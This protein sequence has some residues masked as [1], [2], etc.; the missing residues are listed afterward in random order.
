MLKNLLPYLLLISVSVCGQTKLIVM[1]GFMEDQP[2]ENVLVLSSDN[3]ELGKTNSN[4]V[5]II[6][7]SQE[8]VTLVFDGYKDRKVFAYGKDITV[9]LLP[10]T[11]ELNSAEITNDDS[12]A[13]R[14]IRQVIQDKKKNSIENLKTYEYKSYSKFLVTANKD[15]LPYIMDPRNEEDSSYNDIRKLL[16][17]SHLMLGERAMDHKFSEK[18]GHKNVVKATRISGTKLPMYEFIAMQP[19]SHNF[20][21][22]KIDFFFREF[23]NPI[24]KTGLQEYRYRISEETTLEGRQMIVIAFFPQKRI[25]S[26]PQI[27][28]RLWIDKNTKALAKFYAENLSTTSIAELEMD[29]T[30]VK[31]YWFPLQQRYRMDGG[32]ISYPSVKDSVSPDG[33]VVLDTIKKKEKV[34]LHLTTSFKDVVSPKEFDPKEFKGYTNEIDLNTMD[35]WDETLEEYRDNSLTNQERNTYVKIDSIGKEYNMD[36]NIRLLR[37]ISSGG[38]YSIGK[39]DWDL[40]KLVNYNDYEGFR[41]GLGGNTNYKFNEN[42]SLNG[43]AAYGFRDEKFKFG[44]GLDVFVNKPYSG[45]LFAKYAQDVEASGRNPIVLQNNYLKFLYGNLNNI[46]NDFFYSYKKVTVGYEQ[47]IFQNVTFQLTANYNEQTPEFNYLYQDNR[48]DETY[49]S[50]DTQLALRWAPKD[51]NVRTPYGKVTISSGLPVFYLTMSKGWNVFNADY[52]PA[53]LDFTYLDN[54]RTFLG[55]TN[56]Q[57]RTGAVFGDAPIMNMFEGMGNAKRGDQ[58]FKHFGVSGFNNFETML[59]GEF[60]SDKYFSLQ[61]VHKFAGFKFM[62][63]EV[64]PEFIYRGLIGDMKNMNDHHLIAFQTPDKY[65]QEAGVEF[66]QLVYGILGVGAYYRFGTYAYDTFD[67]NF[68][69]KLTIKLTLF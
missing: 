50:F 34:W 16:D 29:W 23:T 2:M 48:L 49:L 7:A 61:V 32:N 52:T 57:V 33:T 21:D 4:G 24:S 43:Y 30:R 65:Y 5:F 41:L 40:T 39:F 35:N 1:D 26:K 53:K 66:N 8:V 9:L 18:L 46:Y 51:Q 47:D 14:I 22:E 58:I 12:D 28:G 68:F 56:M 17:E 19:I 67:Q 45:K 25:D 6:P 13:R 31:D 54:Y 59:P 42:F 11:V 63:R 55:E 60:Y 15:S 44:G 64:F 3:V 38:K 69:L 20:D 27:K 62:K 10:I 37:I 36:R